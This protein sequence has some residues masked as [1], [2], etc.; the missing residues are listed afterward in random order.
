MKTILKMLLEHLYRNKV[1]LGILHQKDR[2]QKPGKKLK[3]LD[4]IGKL[5]MKM[6]RNYTQL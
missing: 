6:L 1:Y 3:T 5:L 4:K 2:R